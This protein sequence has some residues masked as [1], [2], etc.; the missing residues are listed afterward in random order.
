[1][2]QKKSILLILLLFYILFTLLFSSKIHA[3]VLTE[4]SID[5]TEHA[6]QFGGYLRQETQ[7]ERVGSTSAGLSALKTYLIKCMENCKTDTLDL[8][9]YHVSY[10]DLID[11]LIDILNENPHLFYANA[12][13]NVNIIE[14]TNQVVNL[15]LRYRYDTSECQTKLSEYE[16]AISSILSGMD[17]SWS[18]FEKILYVNDY[19]C[20]NC[21]YDTDLKNYTA[22][23]ALVNQSA[24]CQGYAEAFYDIMK[25]LGISCGYISS[26]NMNHIWNIV[27][28]DSGCYQLDVTWNDP[29]QDVKGQAKHNYLLKSTSYFQ[30]NGHNYS[31]LVYSNGMSKSS[32]SKTTYDSYFWDNIN[33][34]FFYYKGY[35]Y[36]SDRTSIIQYT[37]NGSGL[38]RQKTIYTLSAHNAAFQTNVSSLTGLVYF[39]NRLYFH[40]AYEIFVLDMENSFS[41]SCYRSPLT[42]EQI[43][44]GSRI[45]GF[46]VDS[47][48]LL[49]YDLY[50]NQTLSTKSEQLHTHSYTLTRTVPAGCMNYGSNTYT[51]STCQKS[52]SEYTQA[53]T[54]QHTAGSWVVTE[55]AS[56][57]GDGSK[58]LLCKDCKAR[59]QTKTIPRLICKIGNVYT[60]GNYKYKILTA[61]LG[62]AGT[63]AFAGLA[64]N[65]TSVVIGKT[66]KIHGVKFKITKVADN[67]LRKQKKVT[68]VTL[69]KNITRIGKYA[70]RGMSRLKLIKI[71]SAKINN[72]SKG[73]LKG[74]NK[75]A[76]I[77]VPKSRYIRYKTLF[78]NKGQARTVKIRK[79]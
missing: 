7:E 62:G 4:K 3:E 15:R 59:L 17:T 14:S 44:S 21:S 35:W 60:V 22:Y 56:F 52:Y 57:I 49:S 53:P 79:K 75:H 55:K 11:I 73:A 37:A 76:V 25:R 34:A 30:R 74:I 1:M 23:D 58:C 20:Q 31:D 69:G 78:R 77:K 16:K 70:F 12:Y 27:K 26:K 72:V 33:S 5:L 71:Q 47:D 28:I 67:A 45:Y 61:R 46:M 13:P 19:L 54:G 51:C 40:T 68:S 38:T 48:G 66:V 41:V 42:Q 43:N 36:T 10:N 6:L 63:V 65:C 50:Q 64:K 8:R 29:V 9:A 32:S 39:Q 24:V 2:K 18:S